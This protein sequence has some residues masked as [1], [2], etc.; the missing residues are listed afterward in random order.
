MKTYVT[1]FGVLLA[2]STVALSQ[3]PSFPQ[4]PSD[5]DSLRNQV[6]SRH[7]GPAAETN[8]PLKHDLDTQ[9][10][11]EWG[12]AV[13]PV[14]QMLAIHCPKLKPGTGLLIES[15]RPGSPAEK[16]GLVAGHI[17][18]GVGNEW[19][20]SADELPRLSE[21]QNLTVLVAGKLYQAEIQPDLTL[22]SAGYPKTK[23]RSVPSQTSAFSTAAK[24]SGSQAISMACANGIF[25]IEAS[26]ATAKGQKKVH[27]K[28]TRQQIDK[29]MTDLPPALKSAIEQRLQMVSPSPSI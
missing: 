8:L 14:P 1:C 19:L 15:V 16:A 21:P 26:Y 27:L 20:L 7:F 10:W 28:G 22:P 12:L 17:L 29:L 13:T 24:S 5:F 3:P 23:L 2:L 11:L 18:A 25:D 4:G 6:M 9:I